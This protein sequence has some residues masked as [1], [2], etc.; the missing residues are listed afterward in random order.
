MYHVGIFLFN[1]VELLDFA[2]PLEVFSVTS[3]L[4]EFKLYRVF[5]ISQDGK[6]IKTINGLKV[7]PDYGFTDHPDIDL[8]VIPGGDGTK[9]EMLKEEVLSWL[10]KCHQAS[11]VTMTVCSG[12]RLAGRLGLLNG[13]PC[14]THHEVMEHLGQLAPETVICRDKR[15]V[16][17]GKIMTAGGIS[18][19]I[20]L[21]LHVVEK[22]YGSN[23][24]DKTRIYME[25]G[26]WIPLY[27]RSDK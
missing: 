14:T 15:Y 23:I 2:G 4:N 6:A 16:D 24:S 20:D 25:Y 27:E 8:L 18:A 21:S 9:K 12:A 7:L 10:S 1:D 11:A 22:Q 5:T 19:G 13:L 17:N 3:E 26:D